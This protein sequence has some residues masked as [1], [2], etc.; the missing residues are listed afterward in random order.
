MEHDVI[1]CIS[2]LYWAST[3]GFLIS[4]TLKNAQRINTSEKFSSELLLKIF[5]K[6]N[7]TMAMTSPTVLA[8]LIESPNISTT[9]L[10]SMKLLMC[11]GSQVY[12]HIRRQM[13]AYLPNGEVYVCYG[14]SEPGGLLTLNYPK[15]VPESVG[16]LSAMF[17][18][19]VLNENDEKCGI[20]I[21]GEICF[22]GYYPL[23]GYYNNQRATDEIM[24][25]DDGYFRTGDIGHFDADGNL[26][27]VDRKKDIL[28]YMSNHVSPSEIENVILQLNGVQIVCVVGI[29]DVKY[30]DLP[31]AV[32]VRSDKCNVTEHDVQQI[33]KGKCF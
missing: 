30:M 23:L 32:I 24:C 4:T 1:F 15:S 3:I 19:K 9:N 10:S 8:M 31:A 2:S 14:I 11:G 16:K 28:K 12:E 27:L 29:P 6:Y 26:Y 17:R 25:N 21:D 33:V 22:K 5:E 18:A 7:V 20:N 13:N